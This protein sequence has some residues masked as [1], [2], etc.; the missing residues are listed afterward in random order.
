MS[1]HI[2]TMTLTDALICICGRYVSDTHCV[3]LLWSG[4]VRFRR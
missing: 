1:V 4:R 3:L 2:A